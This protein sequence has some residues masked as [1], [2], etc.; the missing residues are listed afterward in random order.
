MA[1]SEKLD[2]TGSKKTESFELQAKP[3]TV[4]NENG[5]PEYLDLEIDD[6]HL[7]GNPLGTGCWAALTNYFHRDKEGKYRR[8]LK[9]DPSATN[10]DWE[11]LR[12]LC[13]PMKILRAEASA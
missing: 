11:A 3:I 9:L 13:T 1:F 4:P 8:Q 5:K 7:G 6:K 10:E 2:P 12:K